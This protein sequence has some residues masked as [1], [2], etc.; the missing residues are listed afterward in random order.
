[1]KTLVAYY[2][3]TGNTKKVAEEIARELEADTEEIIDKK[4]RKGALGWLSGGRDA[5]M[6]NPTR[7]ECA[8]KKLSDYD[9]VVIGTPIWAW[10]ATPAIRTYIKKQADNLPNVAFFCTMNTSGAEKTFD[11]MKELCRQKPKATLSLF[12][13]EIKGDKFQQKVKGFVQELKKD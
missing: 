1:M 12:S 13:G 10:S 8:E 5:S 2:S 3:R 11:A 7:I 9:L 4:N 6:K